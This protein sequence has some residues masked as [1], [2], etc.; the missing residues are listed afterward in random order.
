MAKLRFLL[1]EIAPR[2]SRIPHIWLYQQKQKNSTQNTKYTLQ[3]SNTPLNSSYAI[4]N[5]KFV[6]KNTE[7]TIQKPNAPN[8]NC[9]TTFVAKLLTF[10]LKIG[11]FKNLTNT[12]YAA[13][14]TLTWTQTWNCSQTF[15][16]HHAIPADHRHHPNHPKS[17]S[18]EPALPSRWSSSDTPTEEA[19]ECQIR[20]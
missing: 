7:F 12:R 14:R 2:R 1:L 4:Q 3:N 10:G 11:R 15:T 17:S 5:T 16:T 18:S 13:S 6:I 8:I 19:L 20:A 9:E